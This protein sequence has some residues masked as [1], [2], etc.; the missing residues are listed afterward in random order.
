MSP[1]GVKLKYFLNKSITL[2]GL[3]VTFVYFVLDVNPVEYSC[4]RHSVVQVS[5]EQKMVRVM[6]RVREEW[7]SELPVVSRKDR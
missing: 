2:T 1:F 4:D 7:R 3:T 6:E 5:G